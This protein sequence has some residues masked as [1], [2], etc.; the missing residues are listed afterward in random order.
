MPSKKRK[1]S[2]V[3]RAVELDVYTKGSDQQEAKRREKQLPE[4]KRRER[5]RQKQHWFRLCHKQ[6]EEQEERHERRRRERQEERL[7][8]RL[9]KLPER[10]ERK[11]RDCNESDGCDSDTSFRAFWARK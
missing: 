7:R 10:Q 3:E 1:E 5:H 11:N 8:E 9:R 2:A 4:S 6:R